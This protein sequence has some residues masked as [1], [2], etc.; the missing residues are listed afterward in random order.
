MK[1]KTMPQDVRPRE[2]AMREGV[3]SLSDQELLALIIRT[4]TKIGSALDVAQEIL[5]HIGGF[6]GLMKTSQ[7]RLMEIHGIKEAKSIELLALGEVALRMVRPLKGSVYHI[8]EP[9]GVLHWLNLEVGFKEQEHFYVVFLN[10]Q[11]QIIHYQCLFIGTVN[12][13]LVHPREVIKEALRWGSVKMILVHN[14]PS[15]HLEPSAQDWEATKVMVGAAKSVGMYI[16]DH[17][18]VSQSE[19]RSLRAINPG[20]FD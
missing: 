8:H 11:N 12:Q 7:A 4:G 19:T 5:I 20:I 10:Q 15:G 13:S 18:I 3:G 2:K 6:Q 9:D 14:H 1:I 17:I 16:L